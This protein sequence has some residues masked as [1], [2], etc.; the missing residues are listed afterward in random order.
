[1]TVNV[2]KRRRKIDPDHAKKKAI[3]KA[4]KT[5][6]TVGKAMASPVIGGMG[7]EEWNK[8]AKK[9][10]KK[11]KSKIS[12]PFIPTKNQDNEGVKKGFGD[13]LSGQLPSNVIRNKPETKQ[14]LK[15]QKKMFEKVIGKKRTKRIYDN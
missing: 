4:G 11:K 13:W 10:K 3:K 7:K 5:A 15:D 1:M 9:S 12:S 14:S 8:A 2:R 6:L